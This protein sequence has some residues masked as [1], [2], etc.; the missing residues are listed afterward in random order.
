V[1]EGL[2]CLR[3][4]S[5]FSVVDMMSAYW[6]I[7]I[8]D[9]GSI[10][11]TAFIC[12]EGLF[13]WLRSPFG[14]RNAGATYDRHMRQACAGLEYRSV[15]IY[16][17]DTCVFSASF[18]AHVRDICV[19]FD[20]VRRAGLSVSAEKC[21]FGA[22]S[23]EYLGY[24]V[25]E[26][27][28]RPSPLKTAAVSRWTWPQTASQMRS[29]LG[30]TGHFRKFIHGYADMVR[31]LIDLTKKTVS[32]FP[33]EPNEVQRRAFDKVKSAL[34]GDGVML[35][36]PD[37]NLPFVVGP[38]D[39]QGPHHR[40]KL[41]LLAI[42]TGLRVLEGARGVHHDPSTLR[43]LLQEDGTQSPLRSVSLHERE[44]I[45]SGRPSAATSSGTAAVWRGLGRTPCSS[46]M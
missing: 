4:K 22:A 32:K 9:D 23:A 8:A 13:E 42:I 41:T 35:N 1:E 16:R 37:Y 17:D 33:P 29:F 3:G 10:E 36:H 45:V 39:I 26:H 25:D 46:T 15:L 38:K 40:Q 5:F 19:L 21:V 6:S 7:P 31:P 18:L 27:G 30:L 43:C 11:K 28:V 44:I 34:V 2:D 24:I 20:R 12:H 14:L